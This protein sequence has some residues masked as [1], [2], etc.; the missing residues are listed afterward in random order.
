MYHQQTFQ[1]YKPILGKIEKRFCV[2]SGRLNLR[3][4]GQPEIARE[5]SKK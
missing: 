4:G 5:Q 3:S 1:K 2:M